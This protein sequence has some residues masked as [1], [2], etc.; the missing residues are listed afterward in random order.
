M[1]AAAAQLNDVILHGALGRQFGRRHRLAV[2]SPAEAVRALC[3]NFPAFGRL[4]A[5]SGERGIGYRVYVGSAPVLDADGLRAPAGRAAIRISPVVTGGKSGKGLLGI[6][7]GIALIGIA[8]PL[9]ATMFSAEFALSTGIALGGVA[10]S[11]GVSLLLGGISQLL[12]PTPKTPGPTERPENTPS[13]YFDGPVNTTAQGQPVP[14]GYGELI[15][16]SAVIS[17]GITAED[18]PL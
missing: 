11:L 16:G 3:A 10:K 9:S 2:R 4:L 13:T 6:F 17:A 7:A 18:A 1:G 12:T 15:I 8:G 14:V 5:T